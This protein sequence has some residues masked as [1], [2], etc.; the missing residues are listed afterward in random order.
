MQQRAVTLA[1]GLALLA[2]CASMVACGKSN[3]ANTGAA[4]SGGGGDAGSAATTGNG[5]A[6]GV[7]GG[8]G[9]SGAAGIGGASAAAGRGGATGTAGRGGAGPSGVG[10]FAP[11]AAFPLKLGPGS[12]VRHLVDQNNK[13][14]LISGDAAWS[15]IVNVTLAD[16]NSYLADRQ[17]RGFN[18]VMV[19]L[20]EHNFS[21]NAPRN[22]AGDMP[23]TATLGG[24]QRD[25]STP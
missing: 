11:P 17:A 1:I 5:G 15:L 6:S 9:T 2:S 10:G 20:I 3:R 24:G 7:A 25:F 23:F 18:T 16:A 4:G 22:L 19:N 14:F 13:P 12:P 21:T 8:S